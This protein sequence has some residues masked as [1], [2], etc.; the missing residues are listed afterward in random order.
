M[1]PS[2]PSGYSADHRV[3]QWF[4]EIV[5]AYSNEL[6][7]RL[8]Q[9]SHMTCVQP[10]PDYVLLQFVIGTSS[11]PVAGFAAL[12]GSNSLQRFTI[13]TMSGYDAIHALPR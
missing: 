11:I 13:D 6:R 5:E 10:V 2:P 12:R 4:W 3:I 8:L 1:T 7:L 9:V